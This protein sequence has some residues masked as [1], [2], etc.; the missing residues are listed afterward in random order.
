MNSNIITTSKANRCQIRTIPNKTSK[1]A[2]LDL[3]PL[4]LQSRVQNSYIPPSPRPEITALRKV[5]I[6]N[7]R[8]FSVKVRVL[9]VPRFLSHRD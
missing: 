6:P 8:S 7:Y 3:A 2:T 1:W 4:P 9:T 5:T